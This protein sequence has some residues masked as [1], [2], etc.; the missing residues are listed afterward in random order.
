M[1]RFLARVL[2][3]PDRREEHLLE[4]A[5]RTMPAPTPPAG[6]RD[7]LVADALEAAQ[8]AIPQ[9]RRS[10][11]WVAWAAQMAV[12]VVLAAWL[13]FGWHG[14][15]HTPVPQTGNQQMT[16]TPSTPAPPQPEPGNREVVEEPAREDEPEVRQPAY[17]PRRVVKHRPE[18]ILGPER[19]PIDQQPEINANKEPAPEQPVIIVKVGPRREG[20]A[21]YA[22]AAARDENGVRTEWAIYVGEK[23][24]ETRQ[25][26]G[27]F[28]SEGR[29]FCLT[30][31]SSTDNQLDR[32][33]ETL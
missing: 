19:Q 8:Q 2:R 24:R 14:T 27:V 13:A 20:E 12:L 29:G 23:P 16:N 1:R 28:D 4:T 18:P 22:R 11:L 32:L 21:S 5:M 10:R 25:E 6:L 33:E 9:R 15:K 17:H 3:I 26:M 30:T 31:T 7:R